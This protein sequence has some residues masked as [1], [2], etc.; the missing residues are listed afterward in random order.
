LHASLPPQCN[1]P[2][3]HWSWDFVCNPALSQQYVDYNWN[4]WLRPEMLQVLMLVYM[5][6]LRTGTFFG[7]PI[8]LPPRR[9]ENDPGGDAIDSSAGSG[10]AKAAAAGGGD[11]KKGGALDPAVKAQYLEQLGLSEPASKA[12]VEAAFSKL[13]E[14]KDPANN[15]NS[16]PEA[17]QEF[18]QLQK[19]KEALL[20]ASL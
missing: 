9:V 13:A 19:A 17:A 8:P 20:G 11:G 15:A 5:A 14:T 3:W 7:M 2:T 10:S 16:A 1:G 18:Q 12:Q 4:S 6:Y